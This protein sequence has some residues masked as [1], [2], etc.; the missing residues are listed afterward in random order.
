MSGYKQG[1]YK[2]KLL[3]NNIVPGNVS[4][5]VVSIIKKK[6]KGKN[7]FILKRTSFK[8]FLE[9]KSSLMLYKRR[10]CDYSFIFK[11]HIGM[12]TV[13]ISL[14]ELRIN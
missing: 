7:T 5:S 13:V 2:S 9:P 6:K 12:H 3:I 1:D 8:L 10:S 11:R 14:S 4:K